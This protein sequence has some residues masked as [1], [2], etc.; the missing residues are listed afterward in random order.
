MWSYTDI[1]DEEGGNPYT[2]CTDF[3]EGSMLNN[4]GDDANLKPPPDLVKGRC[5]PYAYLALRDIYPG[6]GTYFVDRFHRNLKRQCV[7]AESSTKM[8]C[9]HQ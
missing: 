8:G 5:G 2:L 1:G 6:E 9:S 7:A 3:D 4:G